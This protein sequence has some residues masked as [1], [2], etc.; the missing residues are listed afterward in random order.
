ME[1]EWEKDRW[2]DFDFEGF[3]KDSDYA[4]EKYVGE[5]FEISDVALIEEQLGYKLPAAY[6]SFMKKQNGGIPIKG[7]FKTSTPTSWSENGVA[8]HGFLNIATSGENALL[9]D[10]GSR[11]WMEEWGYPDIGIAICDCPSAGHDMIFLD[12]RVHGTMEEPAVVHIDQ[13]FEYKIT[14]L[15]KD[16]ESFVRNLEEEA[17]ED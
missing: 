2:K 6:L 16:F 4:K 3:W 9:G 1:Q 13:E 8:I 5:D 11:F 10:F 17:W 7:D 12:Y 15:A 14:F